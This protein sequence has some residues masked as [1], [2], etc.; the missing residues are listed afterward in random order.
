MPKKPKAKAAATAEQSTLQSSGYLDPFCHS[1]QGLED[2][3]HEDTA[4]VLV[5]EIPDLTFVDIDATVLRYDDYNPYP[6]YCASLVKHE[7]KT[8]CRNKDIGK[9]PSKADAL[10][11]VKNGE[12]VIFSRTFL[13]FSHAFGLSFLV[14]IVHPLPPTQPHPL[15]TTTNGFA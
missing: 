7:M 12:L 3:A 5:T 11:T 10:W 14:H 13:L 6:Y 1:H 15:A 8:L 2:I 9:K 4:D